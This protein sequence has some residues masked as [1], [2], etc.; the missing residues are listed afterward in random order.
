MITLTTA[1]LYA[2]IFGA[3][4]LTHAVWIFVFVPMIRRAVRENTTAQVHAAYETAFT[5]I[6]EESR[7]G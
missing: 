2:L 1:T 6:N 7:R 5:R 3:I 4:V